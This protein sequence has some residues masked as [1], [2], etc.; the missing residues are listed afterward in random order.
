[1]TSH[2]S[3]R[4]AT[5]ADVDGVARTLA[6]AFHD[7]PI[8][9]FLVPDPVERARRRPDQFA[10][11]VERALGHG[12]VYTTDDHAGAIVWFDHTRPEPPPDSDD[13]DAGQARA[14]G[15]WLD[16]LHQLHALLDRH[17]PDAPHHHLMVG[18]VHPDH[19]RTG[20]HTAMLRAHLSVLDEHGISAYSEV[21]NPIVLELARRHGFEAA[22]DPVRLPDGSPLWPVWRPARA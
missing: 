6:I 7:E 1:M 17:H 18:G 5:A 19:R 21:S 11:L 4:L 9:Q 12:A 20:L 22:A 13:A 3:I 15:P 14:W 2:D 8:S 10:L 16:R